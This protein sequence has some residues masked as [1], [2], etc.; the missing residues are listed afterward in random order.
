MKIRSVDHFVITTKD[1]AACLHFYVDI[2]GMEH[3]MDGAQHVLK[4]GKQKINLHTTIGE[5]MP[6][7]TNAGY[8]CQDFC[9]VASGDIYAIKQELESAGLELIEGVTEQAGASGVMDSIYLYDP[10][11][12]LVEIAV[13]RNEKE[14]A[15]ARLMHELEI[16]RKSG[17][18]EGWL[19]VDEVEEHFRIRAE[20]EG[21]QRVTGK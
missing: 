8:G 10:D 2:L 6:Y 11:G 16:G 20:E 13:Y 18:T 12:N 5:F 14:Q 17:E 4:F 1:L 15:L 21:L 7:A 19:S 3:R 9:L